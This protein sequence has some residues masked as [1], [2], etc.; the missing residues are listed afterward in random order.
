MFFDRR[1]QPTASVRL[2]RG[3]DRLFKGLLI[4]SVINGAFTFF[5]SIL[6]A[7]TAVSFLDQ[8]VQFTQVDF[9]Q[10]VAATV[11]VLFAL[12]TAVLQLVTGRYFTARALLTKD[13]KIAPAFLNI[14]YSNA[15]CDKTLF[16][17]LFLTLHAEK[18]AHAQDF[19]PIDSARTTTHTNMRDLINKA[20]EI[21][22]EFTGTKCA[23]CIKLPRACG[24][25]KMVSAFLRDSTS[26]AERINM[27][28]KKYGLD[29]NSAF[30]HIA[31][32]RGPFFVCDDLLKAKAEDDY[33]NSRDGWERAYTATIV[34]GIFVPEQEDNTNNLLGFLCVDNIGGG[35]EN[36]TCIRHI[37]ELSWRLSVM[38]YRYEMLEAI[39]SKT[40]DVS[41]SG[42]ASHVQRQ[43][44]A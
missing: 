23:V 11:I 40:D 19:A 27:E 41:T 2:R 15:I 30:E 33:K 3:W 9:W 35:F 16:D 20:A 25:K 13:E 31:F 38:L 14:A 21:F 26:A 32:R 43:G 4:V 28:K 10:K 8:P 34:S 6:I 22:T 39:L 44:A 37:T 24:D 7:F 18:L 36:S 42:V 17:G 12:T 29:E 1:P 5:W